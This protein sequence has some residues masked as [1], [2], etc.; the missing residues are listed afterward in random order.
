MP[1]DDVAHNIL[2]AL[3]EP[4]LV[5]SIPQAAED[6]LG[7]I[8]PKQVVDGSDT[9]YDSS[10][11]FDEEED[12][13]SILESDDDH[14]YDSITF[15]SIQDSSWLNSIDFFVQNGPRP[16]KIDSSL[17]GLGLVETLTTV[18]DL[19]T[20]TPQILRQGMGHVKLDNFHPKT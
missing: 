11:V 16:I 3:D 10:D 14:L 18:I 7:L 1:N 9:D 15:D 5:G 4:L 19:T 17:T 8:I 2:Q 13:D 6:M 12:D 20:G